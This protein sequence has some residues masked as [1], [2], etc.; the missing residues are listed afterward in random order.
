MHVLVVLLHARF[1]VVGPIPFLLAAIFFSGH[2]YIGSTIVLPDRAAKMFTKKEFISYYS[3]VV[4]QGLRDGKELE[5]INVDCVIKPLRAQWLVNAYNFF[6]TIDGRDIIYKG[7]KKAGISGLFDG[8][9]GTFLPEN[10]FNDIY[11][12]DMYGTRPKKVS[13]R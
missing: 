10:H 12:S 3:G 8:T 9:I 6:S 1:I 2:P 4:Q 5:D 7:W 11:D 13:V